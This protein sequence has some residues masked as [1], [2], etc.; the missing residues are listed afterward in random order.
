MELVLNLE[1][2]VPASIVEAVEIANPDLNAVNS[3]DFEAVKPAQN[4]H[5]K[6]EKSSLHAELSSASWNMIRIKL[7]GK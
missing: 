5:V 3:A 1:D 7:K 4:R 6:L 2:L